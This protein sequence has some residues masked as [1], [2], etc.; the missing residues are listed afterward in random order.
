MKNFK[1]KQRKKELNMVQKAIRKDYLNKIN[2]GVNV[3]NKKWE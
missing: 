3:K 2:V 1:A